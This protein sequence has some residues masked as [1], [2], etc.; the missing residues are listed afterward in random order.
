M[1]TFT[2]L[3]EC[4]EVKFVPEWY[5]HIYILVSL[6]QEGT[7]QSMET[8]TWTPTQTPNLPTTIF[9]ASN[10]AGVMEAQNVFELSMCLTS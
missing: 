5:F 10:C 9:P 8:E 6:V 3:C 2:Q 7:L 4:R 1:T